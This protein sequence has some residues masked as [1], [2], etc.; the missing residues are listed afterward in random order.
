MVSPIYFHYK[1]LII[2]EKEV[3][4]DFKLKINFVVI[5]IMPQRLSIELNLLW[6]HIIPLK[7]FIY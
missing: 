7:Y 3:E 5:S 1:S 6:F 4:N 2:E